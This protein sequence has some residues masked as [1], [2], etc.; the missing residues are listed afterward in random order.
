MEGALLGR[1]YKELQHTEN[2]IYW[3]VMEVV[4]LDNRGENINDM[5]DQREC[6]LMNMLKNTMIELNDANELRRLSVLKA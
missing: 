2:Y 4:T 6:K 5:L 1:H 3:Q